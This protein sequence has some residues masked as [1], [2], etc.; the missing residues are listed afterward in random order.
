M[1]KV[2][3]II[4]LMIFVL[5]GCNSGYDNKIIPEDTNMNKMA[6]YKKITAEEAK[7][8]ID[9]EDVIIVDV[10]TQAEYDEGHIKNTVNVPVTEIADKAE[11]VFDDKSAK[12]LVYCRSGNRS[13][14]A[15][16][17]LIEMGYNNVYDFGGIT[18]WKYE[19]VK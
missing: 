12:I 15:A 9:N 4:F 16:K 1:K 8:I 14:T 18:D 10:R 11:E 13:A 19:I 6:E 2:L 7:G 17:T 3:L 5:T